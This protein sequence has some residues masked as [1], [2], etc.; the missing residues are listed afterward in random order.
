MKRVVIAVGSL[1]VAGLIAWVSVSWKLLQA[2]RER[3]Q[4]SEQIIALGTKLA[5]EVEKVDA[6]GTPLK[7]ACAGKLQS[8]PKRSLAVYSLPLL[9]MDRPAL[10][11]KRVDGVLASWS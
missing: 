10:D 6:Y 4:Q 2:Q 8:G 11:G 7:D 5:D 9:S 1:L 3:H